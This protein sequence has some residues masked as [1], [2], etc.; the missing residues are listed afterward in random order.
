M[1]RLVPIAIAAGAAGFLASAPA[2][3]QPMP[4]PAAA[5]AEPA[6]SL[7]AIDRSSQTEDVRFRSDL[8]QRMTVGVMVGGTGPYRFI[9]DT[10]ADRTV[11][12]TELAAALKLASAGTAPLH[13][14]VGISPVETATVP[15]L[16]VTRNV[17]RNIVAPVLGS[18][19]IGAD[20]IL[21]VDALRSQRI[22]LDF[23]TQTMSVVPATTPIERDAGQNEIVVEGHRRNGRLVVTEANINGISVTVVLDTGAEVSVGNEALRTALFARG[24]TDQFHRVEIQAV[25]GDMIFGEVALVDRLDIG[26]ANLNRLPVVFASAHIFNE[27]KLDRKPALLLGMN[28]MRA[29]QKVS[30]DFAAQRL[31]VV[32]PEHSALDIH[33][34][35]KL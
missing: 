5:H 27:L 21:G 11:V 13:S 3:S 18:S 28:A 25:T 4:A 2:I 10:G 35:Y 12:S 6:P 20:G 26:G 7:P 34:A 31:R 1:L 15:T 22:D 29:F 8:N 19:H 16:Q 9:V 32:I 23:R 30:I 17:V 24:R 33:F 14:T